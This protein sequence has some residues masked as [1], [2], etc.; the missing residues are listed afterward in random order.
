MAE[1]LLSSTDVTAAGEHETSHGSCATSTDIKGNNDSGSFQAAFGCHRCR[2]GCL[3]FH[4]SPRWF[5][6]FICLSAFS[7]SMVVNGLLGVNISTIQR[8]F[9]LSSNQVSWISA[10]HDIV[11]VPVLLVIGYLGL[12]LHRPAWIGGGLIVVGVGIG[13]YIIPHFAAPLYRYVDADDLSNLCVI[14][15][16]N[17]SNDSCP[18]PNY[19]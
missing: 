8:R 16:G 2:R 18:L 19:G 14:L 15:A 1:A 13:I 17:M 10:T 7:Q 5:L 11:G 4:A 12:K 3:Q 6:L 9:S